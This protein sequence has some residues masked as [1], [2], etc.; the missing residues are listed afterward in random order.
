MKHL[1]KYG[2]IFCAALAYL[3]TACT[4]DFEGEYA[5]PSSLEIV[6]DKWNET[7]A[8]KTSEVLIGSMV[9][10]PWLEIFHKANQGQRPIMILD[11][12]ENR[13]D[14][15][16]DTRALGEAIRD[17]I[18]NS[19]KMRFVDAKARDKILKE[20]RFQTESGMVAQ[21]MAARKGRQIGADFFVTGSI[22]SHV[23]TQSGYKT[24][25]YQTIVQ[26]T[27]LE[28]SEI[29]WSQKHNIKKRFKRSS[30]RW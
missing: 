5:D 24:V 1:Y 17:E 14:E 11:D 27:N 29:V 28:T 26:L 10:K 9:S 4:P 6:D 2:A 18:I 16:I 30:S 22:S 13:T 19:G 8:R 3:T 21:N 12:I 7:D 23:H 15:H 20:I 25:T